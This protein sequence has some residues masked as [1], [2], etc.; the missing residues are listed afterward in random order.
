MMFI[1]FRLCMSKQKVKI[2]VAFLKLILLKHIILFL[3]GRLLRNENK[4]Q[5]KTAL[6]AQGLGL[7]LAFLEKKKNWSYL[8]ECCGA[9]VALPWAIPSHD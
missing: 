2:E 9:C 3:G 7:D 1:Q 6:L 5:Q 8:S 4:Q